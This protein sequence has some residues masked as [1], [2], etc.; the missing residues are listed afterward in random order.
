MVPVECRAS[1]D[2][3]VLFKLDI[4]NGPVE[5][6]VVNHLLSTSN[7]D[8]QWIDEFVW[9]HHCKN[10]LMARWWGPSQDKRYSISA[11]YQLFLRFRR[12]GVRAHSWV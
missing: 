3:Y 4:D 9:E 5:I 7:N 1:K 2:D 10:Y 12:Q 8:L 6:A 11:S